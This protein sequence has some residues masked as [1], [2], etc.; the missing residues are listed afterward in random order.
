MFL[1]FPVIRYAKLSFIAFYS[2]WVTPVHAV[3][4]DRSWPRNFLTS[5][6]L[7]VL[8]SNLLLFHC[9]MMRKIPITISQFVDRKM[10]NGKPKLYEKLCYV[11]TYPRRE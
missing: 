4:G 3:V 1:C 11:A 5:K 6:T 10:L 7:Q 8:S 2:Q 9:I